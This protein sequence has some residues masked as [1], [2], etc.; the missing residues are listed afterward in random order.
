MLISRAAPPYQALTAV[1]VH[2]LTNGFFWLAAW[3]VRRRRPL[4]APWRGPA[5][6][7]RGIRF[8]EPG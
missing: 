7:G 1:L 2:T 5:M 4:P 8:G 3:L 6:A